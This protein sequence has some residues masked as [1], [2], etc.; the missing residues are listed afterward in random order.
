MI[1]SDISAAIESSGRADTLGIPPAR[2]TISSRFATAN[3]ALT[4]DATM[5]AARWA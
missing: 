2:E 3:R 1:R 5:P 4:S